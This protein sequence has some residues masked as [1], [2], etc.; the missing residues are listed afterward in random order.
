[1]SMGTDP[2]SPMGNSSIRGWVWGD[3]SLRMDEYGKISPP[4]SSQVQVW[5]HI[6]HPDFPTGT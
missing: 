4:L 2:R 5:D 3:F 1:M 6:P